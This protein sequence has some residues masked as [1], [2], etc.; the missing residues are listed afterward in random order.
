MT[1]VTDDLTHAHTTRIVNGVK[2]PNPGCERFGEAV[3]SI[4]E[5]ADR[6]D[7]PGIVRAL[8]RFGKSDMVTRVDL[9]KRSTTSGAL[10]TFMNELRRTHVKRDQLSALVYNE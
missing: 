10:L 4:L 8:K 1:H 7:Y 9:S 5:K 2:K 6:L 3:N